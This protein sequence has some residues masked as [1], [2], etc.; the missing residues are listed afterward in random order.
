M[1]NRYLC[2]LAVF[3]IIVSLLM[4]VHAQSNSSHIP[5]HLILATADNGPISI[6]RLM[7]TAL[8]NTRHS[9]DF[10]IT[11]IVSDGF[12]QA[13]AGT[14]DGVIAGFPNLH[15]T[16]ANLMQV[17]VPL[18][19][20]NVRVFAREG[21]ELSINNWDEL[22]GLHVGILEN[23]P[24]IPQRLPDNVIVT[25]RAT[26]RAVLNGVIDGDYDVAVLVERDHETLGERLSIIRVGQVD[27]LTEYLYLNNKHE[28]LVPQL[29]VA[30]ESMFRNGSADRIL[31]DLPDPDSNQKRT[32]VHIISSSTEIGRVEQFNAE[33]RNHFENDMSI[34]WMT[35]NLDIRRFTRGQQNIAYIASLLRADIVSRNVAAVIVSGESALDFLKDY[36]YLYFPNIPVLFS[37]VSERYSEIIE[38]NEHNFTGIVKKLEA[39]QTVEAALSIFPGTQNLFV[40]NDFTAEG[41]Q[42][43]AAIEAELPP[44]EEYLNIEY[45]ENS[46]IVMLMEQNNALPENSLVLFG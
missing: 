38:D 22:D 44:L 32:I 33:I 30:L 28:A 19:N 21:S 12:V 42:Y 41:I 37:G 29:A 36:Y 25:T 24:Y 23:R 2:C 20:I 17:P 39:Y 16:Y 40:V 8:R 35:V 1:R 27:Q 15:L 6:S 4:P 7:Y 14:V 18:E 43:R 31:K 26:S 45:N 9:V 3:L 5:E 11:P 46:D 34:E 13:D 10:I